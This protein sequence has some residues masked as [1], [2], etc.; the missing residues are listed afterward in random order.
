[1]TLSRISVP[2]AV[3][4]GTLSSPGTGARSGGPQLSTRVA[5]RPTIGLVIGGVVRRWRLPVERGRARSASRFP[6]PA[7]CA[8]VVGCGR[9]ILARSLARARRSHRRPLGAAL[10]RRPADRRAHQLR[11]DFG[12]GPLSSRARR[13]GRRAR[14]SHRLQQLAGRYESLPW[15]APVSRVEGGIAVDDRA[16]RHRPCLGPAQSP[17]S[18]AGHVVN[19]PR[20]R[21]SRCGSEASARRSRRSGATTAVAI[22]R[23]AAARLDGQS[24]GALVRGRVELPRV[25]AIAE[26]RPAAADLGESAGRERD[27]AAARGRLL[28]DRAQGRVRGPRGRPRLDGSAQRDV[29]AAPARDHRR[30]DGRLPQQRPHVPQRLLAVEGAALRSRPLRHRPVES[31][32]ASIGRASCAC[33]ARSTRT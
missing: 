5:V 9:R 17:R 1:M 14:R 2:T 29:R 16:P 22:L 25:P 10:S 21:R 26:R 15:D 27:R 28:R 11:R 6:Q 23:D 12:G 18:W 24:R 30:H 19:A 3:T 20:S 4:A 8:A 33:S 32:S 13:D 7:L 31:R